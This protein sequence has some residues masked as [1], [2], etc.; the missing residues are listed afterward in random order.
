MRRFLF[1]TGCGAMLAGAAKAQETP[2][3]NWLAD[4]GF[5]L[6]AEPREIGLP[7]GGDRRDFGE[8]NGWS[9]DTTEAWEGKRSLRIKGGRPFTWRLAREFPSETEAVFSLYARSDRPGVKLEVGVEIMAIDDHYKVGPRDTRTVEVELTPEWRRVVVP[10]RVDKKTDQGH[11]RV[12]LLKTWAR[13][14]TPGLGDVW[15][16]AGQFEAGRGAPGVFTT[17][18][19]A[20]PVV[21][22]ERSLLKD[23]LGDN[24]S[25]DPVPPAPG[26]RVR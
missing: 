18:M 21:R 25:T 24:P 10:A 8:P 6:R 4:G 11:I 13:P 20:L 12:H 7:S 5:E 2:P 16:D 22:E 15:L 1:A 9:F 17:M 3:G 14:L 23:W 19:P 26:R